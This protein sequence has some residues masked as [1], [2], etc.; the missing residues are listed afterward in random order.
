MAKFAVLS[1]LEMLFSAFRDVF[2]ACMPQPFKDSTCR[3]SSD[4]LKSCFGACPNP[5]LHV[6]TLAQHVPAHPW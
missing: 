3:G 6:Q 4:W 1:L 5:S 2:Q